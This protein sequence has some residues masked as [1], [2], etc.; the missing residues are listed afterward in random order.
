MVDKHKRTRQKTVEES[1]DWRK[2]KKKVARVKQKM[3]QSKIEL[4]ARNFIRRNK[5]PPKI[6]PN[7]IIIHE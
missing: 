6:K 4:H 3:T 5:L 1:Q 7:I 2:N